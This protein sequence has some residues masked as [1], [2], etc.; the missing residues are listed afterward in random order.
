MDDVDVNDEVVVI[1]IGKD[2]D[3]VVVALKDLVDHE[4]RVDAMLQAG[5]SEDVDDIVS[6]DLLDDI[7]RVDVSVNVAENDGDDVLPCVCMK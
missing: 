1:E 4:V 7:V 3:D 5:M 6:D 2:K